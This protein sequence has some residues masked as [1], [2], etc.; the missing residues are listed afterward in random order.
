M[1]TKKSWLGLVVVSVITAILAHWFML[2]EWMQGR[3]VVGPNDG[4]SQMIPFKHF[5][6]ESMRDG[7]FFYSERFG[8]GGGTFSQLGYYFSTS[9]V[10]LL[11]ALVT[12][13]LEWI[14]VLTTPGLQHWADVTVFVSIIR[15]TVILLI[16]TVFFRLIGLKTRFAYI[17]ATIYGVSILY[18]RHVTYWEFF[19]DAIIFLPL[20]LIGAERIMR[21]G[22]PGWFI[23]AVALSMID[24]FYFAYINF[25]LTLIYIVF[26][27]IIPLVE[28]EL[29]R[30]KQIIQFLLGGVLGAAISSPFFVPAVYGYLNNFRPPFEGDIPLF[31]MTENILSDGKLVVLP[32]IVILCLIL[33]PLYKKKAF[34]L[35]ALMTVLLAILHASPAVGSVFNGLSA[36]QFRWEHMLMLVAGGLAAVAMQNWKEIYLKHVVIGAFGTIVV[37]YLFSIMEL[38]GKPSL[39]A[40]SLVVMALLTC[41]VAILAAVRQFKHWDIA[42]WIVIIG[43]SLVTVN[44]F[45][46]EKLTGNHQKVEQVQG[47]GIPQSFFKSEAYNGE[48]SRELVQQLTSREKDPLTRIDW[49]IGTR[50]NTPIV[51]DFL[52]TSIYSSIL[53]QHLL[54]FYLDD[55]SIDMGRESVSR[56]AGFGGRTNLYSLLNGGYTVRSD[57][58]NPVPFGFEKVAQKGDFKAFENEHRLPFVR[59]TNTVYTE[60]QLAKSPAIAREHAML[61]GVILDGWDE[62]SES[63][64]VAKN[65]MDKVTIHPIQATYE[66]DKLV[67]TGKNGGIDLKVSDVRLL[68]EDVYVSFH[69]E[70]ATSDIGFQ[71]KVNDYKTT[72]KRSDSIYRTRVNDMTIRVPSEETIR[73]RVPKGTY[74]LSDLALYA[75]DYSTLQKAERK[76]KQTSE[77]IVEW[78]GGRVI[79]QL[80][81]SNGDSLAIMPVPFEKGWTAKVNGK[82]VSVL[83]ANY[84]FTGIPIVAG[85]N[86]IEMSYRPPYFGVSLVVSLLALIGTLFWMIRKKRNTP[87]AN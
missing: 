57:K 24:N 45:Q 39:Y 58:G 12:A 15:L 83:K 17:G 70:R 60:E 32:A 10:F 65:V 25:L 30:T 27:W 67:V 16:T 85:T 13:V 14:G 74:T 44:M 64:P 51:Q 11:T 22:K 68:K 29:K 72:R 48:E 56:Y 66:D 26:R 81:N 4:L 1:M 50:N 46:E 47:Q 5:L 54:H 20:L 61:D 59:T 33:F 86:T 21:Y 87:S 36:P 23:A 52:G 35:F 40:D 28:G 43:S 9:I 80:D 55:L 8:L 7:N 49:M 34:G 38:E 75:E 53:N 31:D 79:V 69:L 78:K 2:S 73:I 18:F 62:S 82:K 71:L 77:P 84:A 41:A 3:Y 76:A 6:Y 19:A 37:Y 63:V 42:L